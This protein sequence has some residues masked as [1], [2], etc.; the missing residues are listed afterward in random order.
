MP[1]VPTGR[2]AWLGVVALSAVL[3][4][5]GSTTEEAA[6]PTT[7]TPAATP[8]TPT[9]PSP[10]ASLAPKP[11]PTPLPRAKDGR[12]LR[13]CHD[14]RCEVLVTDGQTITLNDKWGLTPIEIAVEDNAVDFTCSTIDGMQVNLMRQRPDQGGPSK[15]N[16]LTFRVIAVKGKRAVVKISH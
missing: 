14:A 3:V 6:A 2:V 4:G 7:T 12:S 8:P 16:D 5:C 11:K 1:E 15:I 13:A 10:S 9:T